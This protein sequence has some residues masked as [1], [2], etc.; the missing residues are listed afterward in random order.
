MD[1]K[2]AAARE[3][4]DDQSKKLKSE[5]Q[6]VL[7]DMNKQLVQQ[8]DGQIDQLKAQIDEK[9]GEVQKIVEEISEKQNYVEQE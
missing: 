5:I 8:T 4:N 7:Q 1:A 3:K 6:D 9:Y 2:T